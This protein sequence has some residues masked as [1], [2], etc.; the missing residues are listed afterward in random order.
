MKHLQTATDYKLLDITS[1]AF[2]A[3]EMIPEQYTSDGV[4]INPQLD[5]KFI[6][7]NVQT[8][9]V[10]VDGPDAPNGNWIHWLRWNIPITHTIRENE[11]R[12]VGGMNSFNEH[13]YC[14][15]CPSSGTHRYFFKVYALDTILSLPENTKKQRLE[16][17]M[18]D[19]I[20]AFGEI[21]GLYKKKE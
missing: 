2:K 12:G 17:E 10:I 5:I 20:I 16:R 7:E 8:L 21:V 4:D 15:P 19:H 1:P 18:S 6:P 11:A 13:Y 3:G 14:G 9:V